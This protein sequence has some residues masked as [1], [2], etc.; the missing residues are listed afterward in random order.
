MSDTIEAEAQYRQ[1]LKRITALRD[2]ASA[3]RGVQALASA[4][5]HIG[6]VEPEDL[7]DLAPLDDA[8]A[9]IAFT[10]KALE[11]DIADWEAFVNYGGPDDAAADRNWYRRRTL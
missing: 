7:R 10:L 9:D 2:H 5:R 6:Q 8:L 11:G 3:I 4:N 1:A